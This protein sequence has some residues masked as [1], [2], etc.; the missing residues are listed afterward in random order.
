MCGIAGR[1]LGTPGAVGADLVALMDAQV[2]RG[3]D[4]TGFALYGPPLETGLVVRAIAPQRAALSSALD[5]FHAILKAH[6]S[7]FLADPSWDGADSAHV[8]ARMVI[9][10]PDS[11]AAWVR[12]ADEMADRLEIQ[13]VGRSLEIIKD[14]GGASV[15]ADKHGVRDFIGTHGLGHARLA[16]ESSVS[17]TA[18]HPF[19]ARPFA[20]VAIVHNGQ[21]TNYFTWRERLERDG[22]RFM[23]ENDSELIAVWI[24]DRM[25]R[26]M[27]QAQA[28]RQSIDEIDGVFTFLIAD[29]ESMGFAK[30]RW[31]IKPL[32]SVEQDGE[33]AAATEEQAVRTI[34]RDEVDV[35]N[36]DGPGVTMTW[37]IEVSRAAA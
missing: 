12:A 31:A 34:Y 20:D 9:A 32:V 18:S 24:S 22:Y 19:W 37:P 5:E 6:R 17:P 29:R 35:I 25:S 3:A 7:D 13:S 36:Y 15:V 4:S 14:L 2:H 1:I 27:T 28:L 8:S 23:T 26:G 11:M 16:T 30:D 33:L 10:E 21:I